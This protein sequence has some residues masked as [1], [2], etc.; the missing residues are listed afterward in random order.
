MA[1]AAV[2]PLPGAWPSS[3]SADEDLSSGDDPPLEPPPSLPL[4]MP[5]GC[6][7]CCARAGAPASEFGSGFASSSP[8]L[9]S[10]S[11]LVTPALD[12]SSPPELASAAAAIAI[13]GGACLAIARAALGG[14]ACAAAR[15]AGF[16]G[17]ALHSC[18]LV[19]GAGAAAATSVAPALEV[20]RFRLPLLLELEGWLAGVFDWLACRPAAPSAA[21]GAAFAFPPAAFAG[22]PPEVWLSGA[23]TAEASAG[24]G[25][26]GTAASVAARSMAS[27]ASEALPLFLLPDA[28]LC[29]AAAGEFRSSAAF[30]VAAAGSAR[31]F[32]ADPAALC[33]LPGLLNVA[34]ASSRWPAGSGCAGCWALA[35][36]ALGPD[37]APADMLE[38][39]GRLAWTFGITAFTT[40]AACAAAAFLAA[41]RSAFDI[42]PPVAMPPSEAAAAFLAAGAS[43]G[44][45]SAGC[46]SDGVDSAVTWAAAAAAAAAFSMAL[47]AFLAFKVELLPLPL[48]SAAC[49]CALPCL[50]PD[51][52]GEDAAPAAAVSAFVVAVE[53]EAA[54]ASTAT[55]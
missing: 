1:T 51:V 52:W 9:N 31:A 50:M 26:K 46:S 48:P 27:R 21:D 40:F 45:S 43:A 5:A 44:P 25:V 55:S 10:S 4:L 17:S 7:C 28:A 24:S 22:L 54:S 12:P 13:A 16:E 39:D 15:L 36:L 38:A 34:A 37:C 30:G 6:G 41:F 53:G 33:F 49:G 47:L 23:R 11:P 19:L 32:A 29:A 14:A 42:A 8:L 18:P 35:L 2:A 20:V 3:S